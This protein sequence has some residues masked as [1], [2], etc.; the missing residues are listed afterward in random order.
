MQNLEQYML[1]CLNKKLFGLE[2]MGCGMQRAIILLFKGDIV[3]AFYMY[4]AIYTL[5][6]LFSIIAINT[7]MDFKH[8]NK[9]ILNLAIINVFIIVTN[10]I[11]KTFI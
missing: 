1:P 4:P 10:F 9:I 11:I 3:K 6:I 2:C 7:F 5:I 8:S